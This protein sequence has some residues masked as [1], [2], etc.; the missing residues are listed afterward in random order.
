MKKEIS[1]NWISIENT[2][3]YLGIR[4]VTIRSW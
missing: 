2:A 1:E 3:K 4:P